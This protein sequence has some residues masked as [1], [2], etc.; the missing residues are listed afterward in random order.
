M[1]YWNRSETSRMLEELQQIRLILSIGF[2]K[3][4][5]EH[6]AAKAD[7][8]AQY[9]AEDKE[10]KKKSVLLVGL[11]QEW[12]QQMHIKKE[13]VTG[14]ANRLTGNGIYSIADLNKYSDDELLEYRNF[15]QK[16]L[17]VT[18]AVLD[19]AEANERG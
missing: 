18:K 15:G 19:W 2:K 17:K 5:H 13:R 12:A 4:V 10:H 14:V 1:N 6:E 8:L 7:A 16:A 9:K 3:E 11:F